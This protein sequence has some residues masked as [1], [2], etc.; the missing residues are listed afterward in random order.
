MFEALEE[1][2]ADFGKEIIP[3]LVDSKNL[4]CHVFDDYWE[5]IGTVRSFEANLQLTEDKPLF[6]FYDEKLPIYNYPDILPTAKLG[7]CSFENNGYKR[8]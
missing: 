7:E 8:L 1:N 2:A 6:D 3:S 4:K 5:D